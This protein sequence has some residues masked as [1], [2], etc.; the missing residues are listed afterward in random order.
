[1]QSRLKGIL[2]AG[3]FGAIALFANQI[4]A[5]ADTDVD[6]EKTILRHFRVDS[7]I[8]YDGRPKIGKSDLSNVNVSN[9]NVNISMAA[10]DF[11]KT[12]G[13]DMT[14]PGT[15]V[16]FN[17][18]LGEL[19]VRATPI[20]MGKIEHI[21]TNQMPPLIHFVVSFFR[22][23]QDKM[24]SIWKA[25]KSVSTKDK[26]VEIIT[27]DKWPALRRQLGSETEFIHGQEAITPNLRQT[28]I[29]V[30]DSAVYLEPKIFTNKYELNLKA[31]VNKPE[32]IS[33][34]ANL[35]DGQT[36]ALVSSLNEEK[37]LVVFITAIMVDPTRKQIHSNQELLSWQNKLKTGI[38]VQE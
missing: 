8:F 35:L 24:E 31:D 23:P 12:N 9:R 19:F 38:P 6:L 21:I 3:Y 14:A 20:E 10:R 32:T 5:A 22:V 27:I 7:D 18:R 29:N 36:L 34:Q 4:A 13:V 1:M 2:C 15:S 26:S 28:Q 16:F 30:N 37:R 17:S 11:L 25:G 33:A